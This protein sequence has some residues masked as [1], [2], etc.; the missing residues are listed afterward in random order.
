M[1]YNASRLK[2][3]S[4]AGLMIVQEWVNYVASTSDYNTLIS[5]F[6]SSTEYTR[7][8]FVSAFRHFGKRCAVI[9]TVNNDRRHANR[10]HF[11]ESLVHFVITWVARRTPGARHSV[12]SSH[13]IFVLGFRVFAA[14]WHH[15][16][17]V[18][19]E[20]REAQSDR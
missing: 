4:F 8:L 2:R 17:Y 9:R 11:D 13:A 15:A 14:F 6:L 1:F 18:A 7:E 16:Q 3:I 12:S 10:I 19:N 5:G 20:P